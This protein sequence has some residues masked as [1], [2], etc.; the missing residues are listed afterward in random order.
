MDSVATTIVVFVCIFGAVLLGMALRRILPEDHLS[1]D[2]RDAVKLAMGL[3]ATMAALLLG[4]LISSAKGSCDA[5]RNDVAQMAA[6]VAFLDRALQAYG[7]EAAAVRIR[8]HAVISESV[9]QLWPDRDGAQVRMAPDVRAGNSLYNAILQLSP[10]DEAQRSLKS[11]IVATAIETGQMRELLAAHATPSISQPLLVIVVSWL[12]VIF[13]G[14]SVVSP[15]NLTTGLALLVTTLSV[16]G[17]VFL[18]LELDQPFVGLLRIS[19]EP[20]FKILA[21]L[22]N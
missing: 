14:F 15:T 5:A 11:S 8:L 12:V 19:G 21:G 20:F 6:K 22:A 16:T 3:V 10:R 7:P 4:L 17:A 18:I 1:A 2:S 13:L 9:A